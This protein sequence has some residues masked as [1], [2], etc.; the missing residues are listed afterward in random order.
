MKEKAG[1]KPKHQLQTEYIHVC[2][3]VDVYAATSRITFVFCGM[4]CCMY[5]YIH[6]IS[7]SCVV[8]V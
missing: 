4:G 8:H 2:V 1:V 3:Y 6:L 7:V 5:M